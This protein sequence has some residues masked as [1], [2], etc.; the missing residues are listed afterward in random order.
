MDNQL[1]GLAVKSREASS[2]NENKIS[3]RWRERRF[4]FILQP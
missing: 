1:C 2:F 4:H 3:H